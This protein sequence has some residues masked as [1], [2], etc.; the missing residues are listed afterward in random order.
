MAEGVVQKKPP[1][2]KDLMTDMNGS[3]NGNANGA[4][5]KVEEIDADEE[6]AFKNQEMLKELFLIT[7]AIE[8]EEAGWK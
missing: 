8:A 1:P 6:K 3:T 4:V 2:K 7:E 5:V